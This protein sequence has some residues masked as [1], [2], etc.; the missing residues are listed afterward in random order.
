MAMAVAAVW[1]GRASEVAIAGLYCGGED[2]LWPLWHVAA[3]RAGSGVLLCCVGV[4]L[5]N[6]TTIQWLCGDSVRWQPFCGGPWTE[7][8]R[9]LGLG[10]GD[11]L[12]VFVCGRMR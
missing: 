8:G 10:G 7:E 3:A 2:L 4:C 5:Y 1:H 11:M 12:G 6:P 9:V